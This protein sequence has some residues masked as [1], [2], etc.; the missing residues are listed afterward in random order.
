MKKHVKEII[1]STDK[2]HI[3]YQLKLQSLL[4]QSFDNYMVTHGQN[5]NASS[6]L[7][8]MRDLE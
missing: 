3:D 4:S 7:A 2:T 5:E 6:A 1:E 8:S